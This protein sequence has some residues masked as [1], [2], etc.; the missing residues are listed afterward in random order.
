MK[1]LPN[2]FLLSTL[3]FGS[4]MAADYWVGIVDPGTQFEGAGT[5][6]NVYTITSKGVAL[7][8]GSPYVFPEQVPGGNGNYY[9]PIALALSPDHEIAYVAYV[10]CSPT[11]CLPIIVQFKITSYGL[12]YQ[13]QRQFNTGD[14]GL[15]GSTLTAGPNYVIENTYPFDLWVH[16]LSQAGVELMRDFE[17][18]Y[19][20]TYV[21]AA[22]VD[23]TRTYYYSCRAVSFPSTATS[24]AV[25]RFEKGV[26]V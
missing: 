23:S 13:W 20:G 21:V 12:V 8:P 24:V 16:V 19:D 7:V 14:A 15:Q 17:A 2:I 22:S 1:K 11:I 5:A 6:L 10:G 25:F 3:A 9:L 26:D 4:A 18:E